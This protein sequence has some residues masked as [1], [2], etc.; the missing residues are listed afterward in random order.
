MFSIHILFL[1]PRTILCTEEDSRFAYRTTEVIFQ[2]NGF[3]RTIPV[4]KPFTT[5]YHIGMAVGIDPKRTVKSRLIGAQVGGITKEPIRAIGIIANQ[6]LGS[7]TWNNIATHRVDANSIVGEG[8]KVIVF[9]LIRMEFGCPN[10]WTWAHPRRRINIYHIVGA[11]PHLQ[12]TTFPK[13]TTS[14]RHII[15]MRGSI[16]KD[17]WVAKNNGVTRHGTLPDGTTLTLRRSR[18]CQ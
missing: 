15:N 9:A 10:H 6:H 14:A 8:G 2:S 12:I 7:A 13:H 17:A 11:C 3:H 16:R 1:A 5:I 4:L 18:N